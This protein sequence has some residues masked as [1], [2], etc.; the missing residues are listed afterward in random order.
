M[1]VVRYS[2]LFL[3]NFWSFVGA[4]AWAGP[5]SPVQERRRKEMERGA[6]RL[7]KDKTGFGEIT[8]TMS[9]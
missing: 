3:F 5:S 1:R 8:R 4:A 7:R 9:S 6:A 2:D